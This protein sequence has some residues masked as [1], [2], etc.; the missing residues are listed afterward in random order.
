MKKRNCQA[1]R[2]SGNFGDDVDFKVSEAPAGYKRFPK[3]SC[4]PTSHVV[5]LGVDGEHV[6]PGRGAR[7]LSPL[8]WHQMLAEGGSEDTVLLDTRNVYESRIGRFE[9]HG[10]ETIEVNTQHF[11]QFPEFVDRNLER[12]SGKR[13]MMYCTGGVRCETASSYLLSKV[14][15]AEVVQLKGGICRYLEQFR[16]RPQEGFFRGKNFVFDSRRYEPT[17]DGCVTGRCDGCGSPWD[18]YDNGPE[19]RCQTCRVLMLLCD[20]CRAS[21]EAATAPAALLCGGAACS[22]ER[23]RCTLRVH[24]CTTTGHF[25]V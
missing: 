9:G 14:A 18:D 1:V 17:H 4:R 6:R 15:A 19:A 10:V 24:L 11:A 22:G 13:V 7:H 23:I 21:R 20:A 8:E 5:E 25:C 2:C 12:L 3:L 16:D